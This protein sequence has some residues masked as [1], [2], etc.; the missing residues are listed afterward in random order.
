[1][2]RVTLSLIYDRFGFA[3]GFT[4]TLSYASRGGTR[5]HGTMGSLSMPEG[6]PVRAKQSQNGFVTIYDTLYSL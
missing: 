1:M 6:K 4:N 5:H 3:K 2:V